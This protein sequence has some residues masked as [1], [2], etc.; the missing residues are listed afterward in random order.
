MLNATCYVGISKLMA[1]LECSKSAAILY[2]LNEGLFKE[3]V[4]SKEDNAFL[5]KRY[6][7]KL[8]DVIAAGKEDSHKPVLELEKIK[9][10]QALQHND[11]VLKGM[12][13][14]WDTHPNPEW[15][16]KAAKL[17]EQWNDKLESARNLLN[18]VAEKTSKKIDEIG[19]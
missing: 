3:G 11:K 1:K 6:G 9:A 14:Q 8:K 2:A 18:L 17:A 7:R 19:D 4:I 16:L 5:A 12:I 13:A 10:Q 15:R